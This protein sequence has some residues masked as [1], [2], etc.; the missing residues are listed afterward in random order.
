VRSRWRRPVLVVVSLAIA[1]CGAFAGRAS[2]GTA[3]TRPLTDDYCTTFSEYF[4]VTV[5]VE[6]IA[7]LAS[8]FRDL[9]GEDTTST[10]GTEDELDPGELK[11][12]FQ[13]MLSPKFE[14]L[15]KS[16]SRGGPRIMRREFKR[17]RRIWARGVGLLADAGLTPAQI[18]SIADAEVNTSTYEIEDLTDEIE[19]SDAQTEELGRQFLPDSQKLELDDL[20]SEVTDTFQ[21]A[22]T[23]C[24][25]IPSHTIECE[26]VFS[27]AD[28]AE[29]VGSEVTVD[30]ADGCRYVG[31][32][33]GDE[34]APE[35]AV[36][37]YDSD[38]AYDTLTAPVSTQDVDGVGERAVSFDGYSA[39]GKERTCGRTL[40][41]VADGRTVVVAL[42]LVD[43][44]PVDDD[45]LV[46]IAQG[47]IDRLAG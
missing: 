19:L 28:A 15:T 31:V 1:T 45:Q 37:V 2:A 14:A 23:E 30:D 38:R 32:E 3:P 27:E 21:G 43:D 11:S 16:L 44:E 41:A 20:S 42:C 6:F 17:E 24:G 18:E 35:V 34:L 47:V 5:T 10:A 29:V 7:A 26:D 22:A 12:T 9:P 33:E 46:E 25:T 40:V 4:A 36:V 13:V 8:A 39:S